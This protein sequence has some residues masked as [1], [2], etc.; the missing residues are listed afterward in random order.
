MDSDHDRFLENNVDLPQTFFTCGYSIENYLFDEGVVLTGIKK[1]LQLNPADDLC[2]NIEQAFQE[3]RKLF[4]VRSPTILAYAIALKADGQY[5]ILDNVAFNQ[6]FDSIKLDLKRKQ[7]KCAELLRCAEVES[8]A[9]GVVLQYS[10]QLRNTHPDKFIRGKLV[11]Q[12]V[13]T[14]CVRL[15]KKF[16]DTP[17]LNGKPLKPRIQLSKRNLIS[18]FVDFVQIPQRLSDFL[19]EMESTLVAI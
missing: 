3:D 14:F 16:N 6:L 15:E 4:E 9:L 2:G 8:L 13:R 18:V 19:D 11:A 1:H 5:P 17:K 7:V 10:R 12:F